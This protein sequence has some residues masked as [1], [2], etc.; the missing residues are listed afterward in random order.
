[1]KISIAMTTFNGEKYLQDQLDSFI[2][3]TVRP[4]ELVIYDDNSTDTTRSILNSFKI[5]APFDVKLFN[6]H[7]NVGVATSFNNALKEVTGDIVFLSDQDDAWYDDKIEK[8]LLIAK[9]MPSSQLIMHDLEYCDKK[10]RPIGQRKIERL[11][12]Y[13]DPMKSYVTG[14]AM[15]IKKELLNYS[16]PIPSCYAHDS[17]LNQCALLTN[18]KYI[19]NDVLASYRRHETNATS[20]QLLNYDNKTNYWYFFKNKLS[21][22]VVNIDDYIVKKEILMEW[23]HKN[24]NNLASSKI[25]NQ[26]N[27]NNNLNYIASSIDNAHERLQ[28]RK[29]SKINRVVPIL[30]LFMKEGYSC[31]NGIR[32][33]I[34]DF[35]L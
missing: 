12:S 22:N 4:D 2:K 24:I 6:N 25:S 1:M 18:T 16:L 32:S 35:M 9:Q 11:K 21:H 17:W 7:K 19:I 14:M 27:L 3:Q 29:L 33:A 23:M 15:A 13:A 30:R 34:K 5:D 31:F 20:K 28:L 8:I 10:L 26:Y